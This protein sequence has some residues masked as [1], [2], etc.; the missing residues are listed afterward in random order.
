MNDLKKRYLATIC[1]G[2]NWASFEKLKNLS[3]SAKIAPVRKS[4]SLKALVFYLPTNGSMKKRFTAG[5]PYGDGFASRRI[6]G[7]LERQ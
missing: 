7:I 3:I 2:M 1:S 5:N 6:V 4:S